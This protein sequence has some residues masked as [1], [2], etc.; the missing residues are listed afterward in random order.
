MSEDAARQ[1]INARSVFTAYEE[2]RQEAAEVRGGMYWKSQ[3]QTDYLIRTSISNSQKSLGPRSAE[4]EAIYKKFTTRK[5]M[6]EQRLAGLSAEMIR[7]QRMNRAL[8]VGH[9]PKLLVEILSRIAK[10]GLAEHFTVVG[11]HALYAYEA[12]AGVRF[13]VDTTTTRLSFVTQVDRL[14]VLN[15]LQRAAHTFTIR[16]DQSCI[17]VNSRGF[18][19]EIISGEICKELTERLQNGNG[20]SEMVVAST[21]HMARMNTIQ[22]LLWTSEQGFRDLLQALVEQYLPHLLGNG[23]DS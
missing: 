13:K 20:F 15:L 18:E 2:A 5:T 7:Q 11:T 14:D 12:A 10:A 1:Y 3:G 22:P 23:R 16:Q 4:S 21:G 9:A 6:A 19:V 8:H 17:A